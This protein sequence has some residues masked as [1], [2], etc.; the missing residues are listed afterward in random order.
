MHKTIIILFDNFQLR[1][2]RIILIR[3]NDKEP[4]I[5][6]KD[7]NSDYFFVRIIVIN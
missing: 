7:Y 4:L 6:N 3:Y 2:E 1:G 5:K